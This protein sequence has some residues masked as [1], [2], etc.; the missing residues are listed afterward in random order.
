MPWQRLKK[1]GRKG[2]K[3]TKEI[4]SRVEW[5]RTAPS[6]TLQS[7]RHSFIVVSSGVRVFDLFATRCLARL[8]LQ[9]LVRFASI[10]IAEMDSIGE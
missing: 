4:K 2:R 3:K 9:Q 6:G 5:R 8:D 1:I 10:L 7:K